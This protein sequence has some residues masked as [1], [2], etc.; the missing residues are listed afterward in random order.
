MSRESIVF[1]IGILLLIVPHIGIPEDWKRYF[2]IGVG[3]ILVLAGYSLR[4][5]SYLR[6]IEDGKGERHTDTFVEH[7]HNET[8]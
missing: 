7:G 5:S 8:K 4:R 2:I 3:I 1:L 6:S